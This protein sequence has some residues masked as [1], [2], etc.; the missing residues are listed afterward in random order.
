MPSRKLSL[1]HFHI[2]PSIWCSL[3]GDDPTPNHICRTTAL[4]DRHKTF[5]T[6]C[7][8]INNIQLCTQQIPLQSAWK[9]NIA[10]LM[11]MFSSKNCTRFHVKHDGWN[12]TLRVE[13]DMK[14][15]E[16][17]IV[18][19]TEPCRGKDHRSMDLCILNKHC[20][21]KVH[22]LHRSNT[23]QFDINV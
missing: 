9:V 1:P 8:P 5:F 12:R 22:Q 2:V 19:N 10:F 17:A 16:W 6:V 7:P 11:S 4:L 20:K 15:R 18:V 14:R 21:S 23:N 13:C 3:G